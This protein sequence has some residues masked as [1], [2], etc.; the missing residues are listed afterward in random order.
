VGQALADYLRVRNKSVH[1]E[2]FLSISRPYSP[3]RT[4]VGVIAKNAIVRCGFTVAHPGSHT[5]RYARAQSLFLDERPL[6]EIASVLGHRDLRTTLGYIT[7]TV[8]P[9]RELTMNAGEELS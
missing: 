6:P 7:F 3:L 4:G 2:V 5:F 9:L 1:R 8:H